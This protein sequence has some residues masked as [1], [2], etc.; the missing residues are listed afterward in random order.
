M[1]RGMSTSKKIILIGTGGTIAGIVEDPGRAYVYADSQ[2][3]I[4]AVAQQLPKPPGVKIEPIQL[5]KLGSEDFTEANWRGLYLYVI[6]QIRRNDVAGIVLTQGTDTLEETAF[7]LSLVLETEKPI[8]VTGAMRPS[9]ALSSDAALNI[10]QSLALA[11]HPSAKGRGVLIVMNERIY[12]PADA[13]KNHTFAADSFVSPDWGPLGVMLGEHPH[14]ARAALAT[15]MLTVPP[16]FGETPLPRV[17]LIWGFAGIAPDTIESAI[18]AGA[19]GI[20]YAGTGN[21]SVAR[22]VKQSLLTAARQGCTVVRASRVQGGIVVRNASE[23][24]DELRTIASG[25]YSALK[26]RV[27]LQLGLAL[28]LGREP[29]QSVFEN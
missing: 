17:D 21:G 22:Q 8:V 19:S 14:W 10:Y 25:H 3:N 2:L 16:T 20:V 1:L 5:W 18:A 24:D 4:E 11:A 28:K 15:P 6:Q 26:S 23:N 29:L 13:V 9:K 27:L 7:F 12:S